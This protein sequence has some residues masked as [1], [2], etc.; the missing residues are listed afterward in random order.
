MRQFMRDREHL[1]RMAGLFLVGIVVFVI[2]RTLLIPE[3]FGVYGHYRAG[4]LEDNKK[5]KLVH[6]GRAACADCHSDQP[7]ALKASRHATVG[8]E[9][10]H[11]PLAAHAE[12]PSKLTPKRPDPKTL[13][14]VCHMA[15]VAKPAG[16]KQIL[17]QDHPEG[18]CNECHDPHSPANPPAA[19]TSAPQKE[20]VK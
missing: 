19:P 13:C 7:E 5:V 4:A 3:G 1:F 15:N 10:C 18:V 16:F 20:A 9:A 8:C 17:L 14:L 12:D 2:V 11:G 6:A